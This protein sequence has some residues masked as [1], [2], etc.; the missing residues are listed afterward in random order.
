MPRGG[1]SADCPDT[2]IQRQGPASATAPRR[3][4]KGH[5][6]R[7]LSVASRC[8][9]ASRFLGKASLLPALCRTSAF[10]ESVWHRG[11]TLFSG[12]LRCSPGAA[13]T[14]VFSCPSVDTPGPSGRA[15]SRIVMQASTAMA[16][17]TMATKRCRDT[18]SSQLCQLAGLNSRL[19][20]PVLRQCHHAVD[21]C[22]I[23]R[24]PSM[25]GIRV[26]RTVF[27]LNSKP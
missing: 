19:D 8:F 21:V 14:H 10:A 25:P 4:T 18:C 26:S 7:P 3:L 11:A 12:S 23:E 2:R 13:W 15:T 20:V 17:T 9:G 27:S 22:P 5:P 6:S 16:N 24:V 1:A